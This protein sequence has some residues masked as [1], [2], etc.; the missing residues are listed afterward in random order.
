[1]PANLAV[2]VANLGSLRRPPLFHY[3]LP[4]GL[5]RE[6]QFLGGDGPLD[7]LVVVE[8]AL[9]VDSGPAG[10]I[11]WDCRSRAARRARLDPKNVSSSAHRVGVSLGKPVLDGNP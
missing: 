1:M 3:P 5:L 4:V 7:G 11:A 2:R 8:P 10:L 9:V 6:P